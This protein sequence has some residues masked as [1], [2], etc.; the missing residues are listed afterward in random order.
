M[1]ALS[2]LGTLGERDFVVGTQ[3]LDGTDRI[4]Y[5]QTT[6]KLYYDAD[7]NGSTASIQIALLGALPTLTSDDFNIVA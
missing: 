2:G 5:N 7:G 6:G 3:A 4:I 1:T